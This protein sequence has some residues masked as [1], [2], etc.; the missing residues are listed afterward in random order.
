[1]AH[2]SRD[3]QHAR[4]VLQRK[5]GGASWDRLGRFLSVSSLAVKMVFEEDFFV[6][7][8]EENRCF[9]LSIRSPETRAGSSEHITVSEKLGNIFHTF[10][11][12]CGFMPY[13]SE[14]QPR[15]FTE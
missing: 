7:I 14:K 12:L 8:C 10:L 1:M 4:R 3:G 5:L 11:F 13:F 9:C 2:V 15:L 6:V